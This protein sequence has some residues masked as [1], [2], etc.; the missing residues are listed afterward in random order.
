VAIVPGAACPM[1]LGPNT[2]E[3]ENTISFESDGLSGF[4]FES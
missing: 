3:I 4:V 2:L 1:S